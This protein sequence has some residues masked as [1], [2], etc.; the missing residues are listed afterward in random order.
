VRALRPYLFLVG[1]STYSADKPDVTRQ[2]TR[3]LTALGTRRALQLE[4]PFTRGSL[5]FRLAISDLLA[6]VF[7]PPFFRTHRRGHCAMSS[8]LRYTIHSELEHMHQEHPVVLYS[9]TVSSNIYSGHGSEHVGAVG[10]GFLGQQSDHHSVAIGLHTGP[11]VT[12]TAPCGVFWTHAQHRGKTLDAKQTNL[13][14]KVY[15]VTLDKKNTIL[16]IF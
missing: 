7:L 8:G 2:R 12:C 10:L 11:S 4:V 14:F 16:Y 13:Y 3:T 5:V 1:P 15:L 6:S 9:A